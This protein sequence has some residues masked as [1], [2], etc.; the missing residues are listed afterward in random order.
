MA[1]RSRTS[2]P[3]ILQD[4]IEKLPARRLSDDPFTR[5]IGSIFAGAALFY[6]A[7][8]GRN[9]KVKSY[10]DALVHVASCASVG[11]GDRYAVTPVGRIIGSAVTSIIP[12]TG[13]ARRKETQK[14]ILAALEKILAALERRAR[15]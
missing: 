4:A 15:T 7:E 10:A 2:L 5:M 11:Y 1:A 14:R 3:V 6:Q 9:P 12:A 13:L 8:R